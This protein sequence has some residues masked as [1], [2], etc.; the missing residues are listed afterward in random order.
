MDDLE[1]LLRELKQKTQIDTERFLR[2]LKKRTNRRKARI[3]R[4]T[5]E[6]VPLLLS[7]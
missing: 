3:I 2:G 5:T 4:Q 1:Y 7:S 6:C